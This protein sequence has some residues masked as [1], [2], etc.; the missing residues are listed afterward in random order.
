[1]RTHSGEKSAE[2]FV[3]GHL[4]AFT[5]SAR[6]RCLG[7][8]AKKKRKKERKNITIT[9]KCFIESREYPKKSQI[10]GM[11]TGEQETH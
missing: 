6:W 8:S 1:M 7:D 9:Q 11:Y 10:I 4:Q 3:V 2:S 5:E